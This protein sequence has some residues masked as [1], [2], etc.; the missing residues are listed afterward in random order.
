M[1]VSKRIAEGMLKNSNLYINIDESEK[2]TVNNEY[3]I[4]DV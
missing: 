4:E 3:I 1:I 2:I